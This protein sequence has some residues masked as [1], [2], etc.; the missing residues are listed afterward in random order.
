MF[1]L[2]KPCDKCPFRKTAQKRWLGRQRA[3]EIAEGIGGDTHAS[4]SC[5]KTNG[6]D[7]NGVTTEIETSQHCAGAMIVL[8]KINN[9]NIMMRRGAIHKVFDA[10][11]LKDKTK[12]FDTLGEFVE[13]H[14]AVEM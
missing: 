11:Q 10:G 9:P 4:F 14:S 1:D 13:H 6:F 5:H 3:T 7:R 12:V 8:D 2:K